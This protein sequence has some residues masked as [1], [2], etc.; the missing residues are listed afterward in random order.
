MRRLRFLQPHPLPLQRM[1]PRDCAG[2]V[3]HGSAQETARLDLFLSGARTATFAREDQRPPR[4]LK[5]LNVTMPCSATPPSGS[6]LA[7]TTRSMLPSTQKTVSASEQSPFGAEL[8]GL[9]T[10]CVRFAGKVTLDHA[11]LGTGWLPTFA[12]QTT[13]PLGP[14]KRFQSRYP[15]HNLPLFQALP[16]ALPA[17]TSHINLARQVSPPAGIQCG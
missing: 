8:H 12:G 3:R 2:L 10:P 17:E 14:T 4:F 1:Y 13:N 7:V 11:T 6:R 9:G 16:G 5:D 15:L